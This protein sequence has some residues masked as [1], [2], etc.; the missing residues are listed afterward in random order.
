[1]VTAAGATAWEG[2]MVGIPMVVVAIAENQRL[3]Y[4]WARNCGLPG[5]NALL[6]D[7]EFLAHQLRALIP[8][9]MIAPPL[10]NGAG[11]VANELARLLSGNP[12]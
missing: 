1:M 4:R 10:T 2:A 8:A 11:R 3:N 7:A 12:R 6:V 9:A 5:A